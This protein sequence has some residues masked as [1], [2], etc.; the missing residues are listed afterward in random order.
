MNGAGVDIG[1]ETL[2]FNVG[3]LERKGSGPIID[4]VSMR[5]SSIFGILRQ[6]NRPLSSVE[7]RVR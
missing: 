1:L 4:K 5:G 6:G 2:G 3:N 7:N